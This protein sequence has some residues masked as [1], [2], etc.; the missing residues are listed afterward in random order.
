LQ[1]L[2]FTGDTIRVTAA[3]PFVIKSRVPKALTGMSFDIDHAHLI[4]DH[5]PHIQLLPFL[6][7]IGYV[8]CGSWLCNCEAAKVLVDSGAELLW[9][10]LRRHYIS[11][12]K[13]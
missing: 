12:S 10:Q 5:A 1:E 6:I 4:S 13:H 9:L 3:Q 11:F 8:L 7:M 2:V